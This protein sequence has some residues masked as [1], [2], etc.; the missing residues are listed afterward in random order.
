M[1]RVRIVVECWFGSIIGDWA[2]IDFKRKMSIGNIPDGMLYE[3]TAILTNCYT[4]AN[5]QNIISSY[6]DVVPPSFEEYFAPL[7]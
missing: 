3:V 1:S 6:F 5:R 7:P 2:M 4:I